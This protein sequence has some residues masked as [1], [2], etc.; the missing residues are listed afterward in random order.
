MKQFAG[1]GAHLVAAVRR[2]PWAVASGVLML[3]VWVWGVIRATHANTPMNDEVVHVPQII[4]FLH[5]HF[6]DIDVHLTNIPGYHLL[7]A[8]L[9]W[10]V[11]V[12]STV[13][14]RLVNVLFWVMAVSIFHVFRREVEHAHVLR[15][16]AQ[17][18]FF[19]LLYPYGFTVYTDVLSL[20]LVLS[21][22]WATQRGRHVLSGGVLVLS[23]LVRQNNVVWAGFLLL[24][25]LWPIWVETCGKPWL[26]SGRVFRMAWTYLAVVLIFMAYWRWNG[27]IVFSK[28]QSLVHP[29]ASFHWGNPFFF[30]FASGV[31]LSLPLVGGLRRFVAQV[32][33]RPWLLLVPATVAAVYALGLAVTNPFNLM[34]TDHFVHNAILVAVA[35]KPWAWWGFGLIATAAACGFAGTRFLMPQAWF[36]FPIALFYLA[37]SWLIEPRYSIIPVALWLALRRQENDGPER[38]TL[39]AWVVLSQYLALGM[40]RQHFML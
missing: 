1:S 32:P 16:T 12:E 14:M 31:L 28:D 26:A 37:G 20:A 22:L 7:I 24:F 15:A 27:T 33:Q 11:G 29:D 3:L 17:F 21:A 13:A 35:Q 30:L 23:M 34:G 18:A 39:G 10:L 25:A 9:L 6:S 38:V 8:A 36:M 5:G 19:P 4:S 40:L 2:S